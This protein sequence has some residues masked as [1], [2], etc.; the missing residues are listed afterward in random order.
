MGKT[1]KNKRRDVIGDER[2][3]T[4]ILYV[5]LNTK[6]Q[7]NKHVRGGLEKPT[8]TR[9]SSQGNPN[10]KRHCRGLDLEF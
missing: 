10:N 7:Q 5:R 4:G 6:E 3:V 1:R 9:G 2:K 8:P